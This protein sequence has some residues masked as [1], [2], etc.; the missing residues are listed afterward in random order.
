M[1]NR[2]FDDVLRL[3][4]LTLLLIGGI[5]LPTKTPAEADTAPPPSKIAVTR[6]DTCPVDLMLA[7]DGSGSITEEDF[8]T[9]RNFVRELVNAIGIGPRNANVGIIQFST[10]AELY[11]GLSDN[12]TSVNAAIDNMTQFGNSTNIV[13]AIDLAQEQ[14]VTRRAGIPRVIIVLTDGLHNEAGNPIVS[15]DRARAAGTAVY[16][17]AVGDLALD[18]LTQ[19]SGGEQN[20]ITV[21]DFDS[22]TSILDVLVNLTCGVDVT[23]QPNVEAVETDEPVEENDIETGEDAVLEVTPLDASQTQIVFSSDRDGDFEIFVMNADGSSVRQLTFNTT[24]DEKPSWSKDGTRI[25][26]SSGT[27][28]SDYEIFVMNADG[29]DQTRITDDAALN[30]GPAWSPDGTRIA[31]HSNADGNDFEIF[32]MNADGSN[33]RQITSNAV[34]T[35]RSPTWSPDGTELI[36]YSDESGG[37]ELMRV[38]LNTLAFT[39]LT[40]N[41]FYDGQPDWSLLGNGVLFGS[42]QFDTDFE[43]LLMRPDGSDVVRLTEVAGID[44]D[45]VWSP[46]GRQIAFESDRTGNY[47]IWVMNADGTNQINLTSGNFATDWSPDWIQIPSP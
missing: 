14:F 19:I 6:Q 13:E 18:E 43:I 36:Y 26:W 20:V 30:F 21:S 24:T 8:E 28:G 33:Q 32:V 29:T 15:A 34:G 38:N 9:I 47:D 1:A 44:D 23:P 42:T 17:V 25:A 40:D 22:L 35:D 16:G 45:P 10:T 4:V 46:D 2:N 7:I 31:Y 5:S 11:I 27:D 37:R 39:R 12:P 3:F 41:A